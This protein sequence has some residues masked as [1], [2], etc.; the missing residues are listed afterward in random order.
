MATWHTHARTWTSTQLFVCTHCNHFWWWPYFDVWR[1][2]RL[3]FVGRCVKYSI[4]T[5]DSRRVRQ[6]L[7]VSFQKSVSW[8][9]NTLN[10]AMMAD[11]KVWKKFRPPRDDQEK[12]RF[13]CIHR[14]LHVSC[15][16]QCHSERFYLF[17][18]HTP[19]CPSWISTFDT[20]RSAILWIVRS[21][22]V[23]YRA[24]LLSQKHCTSALFFLT[25]DLHWA[26]HFFNSA[27]TS[28]FIAGMITQLN[29]CIAEQV[30]IMHNAD[31]TGGVSFF[32]YSMTWP[33]GMLWVSHLSV[34]VFG[35][36]LNSS[37][38]LK[39]LLALLS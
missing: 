27:T 30:H 2:H 35:T 31:V 9:K 29:W 38:K 1:H 22:R 32:M 20:S 14:S 37:S 26:P 36:A 3:V 25:P 23:G 8:M 39:S 6:P 5:R 28:S 33:D 11:R 34:C 18:K 16:L 17:S 15:T 12:F 4:P 10:I 7:H 21:A 24:E 13:G 19:P